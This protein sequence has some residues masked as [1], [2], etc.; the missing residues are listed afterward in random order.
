MFQFAAMYTHARKHGAKL[1]LERY[2]RNTD[3]DKRG[4]YWDSVFSRFRH[5]LVDA[6]DDTTLMTYKDRL[7]TKYSPILPVPPTGMWTIGYFQSGRYFD[8]VWR[9]E[10]RYMMRPPANA[11]RFVSQKYADILAVKDRVVVVHC[12]RTDYCHSAWAKLFHG[13]L[14]VSYYADAMKRMCTSITD[15]IFLLCGDDTQFWLENF[16]DFPVLS[17]HTFHIL[18]D[19]TDVNVFTLLT[20]FSHF[21]ISNSTFSWWSAVL[22]ADGGRVIAPNAWFGPKG[23]REYEDVYEPGWEKV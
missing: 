15:P 11:L 13:P 22:G 6:V 5:T 19:E 2:K 21:I 12:R 3:T 16:G 8:G 7:N 1:V 4:L 23:P 17:S 14:P 20:Q 18:G 10:I 9:K